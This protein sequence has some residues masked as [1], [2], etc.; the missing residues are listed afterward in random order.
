M[1][2]IF[3]GI[4][5]AEGK[6]FSGSLTLSQDI[7]EGRFS[8]V[9]INVR[10]FQLK[11]IINCTI[12]P[13]IWNTD[14][15]DFQIGTKASDENSLRLLLILLGWHGAQLKLLVI[16]ERSNKVRLLST[17]THNKIRDDCFWRKPGC[18]GDDLSSAD[19]KHQQW[20]AGHAN[21]PRRR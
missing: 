2:L 14:N 13:D 3:I 20:E 10:L 7:E 8:V 6:V 9:Q 4:Y 21:R 1:I 11:T 15:T 19:E 16:L 17:N 12:L 5:C 18:G